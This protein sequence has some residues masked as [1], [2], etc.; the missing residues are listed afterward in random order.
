MGG[1]ESGHGS[2]LG[3]SNS[4]MGGSLIEINEYSKYPNNNGLA[5]QAT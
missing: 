2:L 3:A 5:G 4:I 1:R